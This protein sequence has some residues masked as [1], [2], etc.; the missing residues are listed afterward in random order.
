[1][2][3][4]VSEATAHVAFHVQMIADFLTVE[5]LGRKMLLELAGAA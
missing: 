5:E 1:M 2:T 4:S 3:H